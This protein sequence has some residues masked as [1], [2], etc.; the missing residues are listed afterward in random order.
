MLT[1]H[2]LQRGQSERVVWLCEELGIQYELKLHQR[3]KKTYLAPEELAKLHPTSAAPVIEDNGKILAESGAI[4]E[5]ILNIYGDGKLVV[6]PNEPNY[7]D[8]LYWLHFAN[9]Y[10]QPALSRYM[11]ASRLGVDL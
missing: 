3:N 5:Y 7:M 1:V 11:L 2:H 9:G 8:Y 10:F 6:R 4:F